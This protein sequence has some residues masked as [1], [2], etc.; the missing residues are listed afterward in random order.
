[1]ISILCFLLFLSFKYM[2]D[3]SRSHEIDRNAI[4]SSVGNRFLH[5]LLISVTISIQL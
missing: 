5:L 4:F 1:M 3:A 2:N